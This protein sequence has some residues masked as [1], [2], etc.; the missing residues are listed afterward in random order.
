MPAYP[1]TVNKPAVAAA[2]SKAASSYDAVASFQREVGEQLFSL[3]PAVTGPKLLDAGCGTGYFSQRWRQQGKH[4]TALD[5]AAGMLAYAE[6][7]QAAHQ[8]LLGDIE[9]LPLADAS[10]DICFS[11]LV[12]QWCSA[13][14]QALSEL[15]RVTRPGG[16]ILFA[17]LLQC[18]CGRRGLNS[19]QPPLKPSAR[20]QQMIFKGDEL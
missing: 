1:E 16:V 19:N 15:Y 4:V 20:E 6:Q 13:L 12:L 5:L 7:Q 18:T 9:Q 8:Y 14:P 3:A 17:T 10:M 2:F 11:S